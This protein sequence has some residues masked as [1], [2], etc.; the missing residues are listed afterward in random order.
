[1]KDLLVKQLAQKLANSGNVIAADKFESYAFHKY[2]NDLLITH[3]FYKQHLHKQQQAEIR[4]KSKSKA[5]LCVSNSDWK[6][7]K[8][9]I[10]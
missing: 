10:F 5:A 4:K 1:M 8:Q 7:N 3:F 9:G 6:G 2:L